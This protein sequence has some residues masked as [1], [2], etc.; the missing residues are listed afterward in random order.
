MGSRALATSVCCSLCSLPCLFCCPSLAASAWRGRSSESSAH[1]GFPE[2]LSFMNMLLHCGKRNPTPRPNHL[3]RSDRKQMAWLAAGTSRHSHLICCSGGNDNNRWSLKRPLHKDT[4][5]FL[6]MVSPQNAW[7][8]LAFLVAA[9]SAG[10]VEEFV[11][12]GYIQK[13][14]QALIGTT[15]Q[16][17]TL[18]V[19]LFTSGHIY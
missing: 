10:F 8:A 1:V 17:S 4:P 11:F 6:A 15:F 9:L 18:Q 2:G 12:R 16:A 3:A 13:Q 5:L 7:E 14:L 19:L